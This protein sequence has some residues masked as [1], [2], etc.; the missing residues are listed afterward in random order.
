MKQ[1]QFI[2]YI[3]DRACQRATVDNEDDVDDEDNDGP[4]EWQT[5]D[6]NNLNKCK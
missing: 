4:F 2:L 6:D 1:L 3:N 5:V